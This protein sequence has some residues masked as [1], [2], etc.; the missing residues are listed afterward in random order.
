M[1]YVMDI[2][3]ITPD[4]TP[5]GVWGHGGARGVWLSALPLRAM[6]TQGRVDFGNS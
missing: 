4:L 3:V 1:I 2:A 5:S 6:A